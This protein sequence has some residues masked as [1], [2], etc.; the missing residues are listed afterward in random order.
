MDETLYNQLVTLATSE[1]AEFALYWKDS[2]YEWKHVQ[3]TA[4]GVIE[5]M[6]EVVHDLAEGIIEGT[7]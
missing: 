7:L 3:G 1:N 4:A 6:A 2:N 5:G